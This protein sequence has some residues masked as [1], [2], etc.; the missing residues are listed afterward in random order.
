MVVALIALF[1]AMGGTGY[2]ATQV[3][4]SGG[5]ATTSKKA[6]G[7]RGPR[8]RR[9]PAGPAGP[10]GP[11]GPAG[12]KGDIGPSNAFE[13][14]RDS[15]PANITSTSSGSPTVVATLKNLPAGSYAI[16]AKTVVDTT[17]NS[18]ILVT[19]RLSAGGDF[20]DSS[21]WMGTL[22]TGDVFRESFPMEVVHVFSGT[23]SAQVGCFRS[24]STGTYSVLF[25]K[26]IAVKVGSATIT[27]VSG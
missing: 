14:F 21:S 27:P 10:T 22:V 5:K 15:G 8:G 24:S 11:A 19:C 16:W 9:G 12:P 6:K 18:D 7:K 3:A 26:I 1:V 13:A 2:A 20:D 23:G 17:Q 4:F 25:T